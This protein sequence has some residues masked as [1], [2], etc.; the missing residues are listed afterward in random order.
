MLRSTLRPACLA[1]ALGLA[2]AG[3]WTT[4]SGTTGSVASRGA[5]VADDPTLLVATTRR[6]VGD[7]LQKPWF[8]TQRAQGLVFARAQVTP[9]EASITGRISSAVRGDWAVA[10]VADLAQDGAAAAFA[11][12]ALGRD[13]LLYVHGYRE[14]FE[15]AALSTAQ[16]SHGIGFDGATALFTWPSAGSTFNYVGDREAAM[17][18]RDALEELLLA[19]AHSPSGGRIHVVAHSMGT[20][21]TLETLRMLRASGG[22]AAMARIASIVMAAPDVDFDLFARSMEKLGPDA[23]KITVISSRNDR[24]LAVS[25]Q[26]AG[27]VRAGAVDRGRL[28]ALGVRVADA[29]EFTGGFINH[30]LFLSNGDVQQVVRRAIERAGS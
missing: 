8:G 25:S 9:P 27:G 22:D 10:G 5:T 26:I 2:L 6:P 1:A 28:E 30:D 15:T 21:L 18:S 3:C 7:P 23:R 12:A 20:L 17:W 16:L 29:S 24:A 11:Q 13:V 19:L 14:S 4:E